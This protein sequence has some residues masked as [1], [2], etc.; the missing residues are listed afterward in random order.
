[1][2]PRLL[3]PLVPQWAGPQLFRTQWLFRRGRQRGSALRLKQTKARGETACRYPAA[4][5]RNTHIQLPSLSHTL[6]HT[7]TL[8]SFLHSGCDA[9]SPELI[10]QH[11]IIHNYHS[12]Y[13]AGL[14]AF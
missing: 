14:W 5:T 1:M 13:G 12:H 2:S 3:A 7:H 10:H 4:S 11:H 8:P 9:G 6:T